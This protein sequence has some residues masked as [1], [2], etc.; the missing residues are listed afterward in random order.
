MGKPAVA[1]PQPR[2]R[3]K[4]NLH[5]PKPPRLPLPFVAPSLLQH[6]LHSGQ[7]TFV[8]SCR[9][10]NRSPPLEES[11]V[12]PRKIA[13]C[14]ALL[15]IS[16]RSAQCDGDGQR[17]LPAHSARAAC[18][19]GKEH[20]DVCRRSP[21]PCRDSLATRRRAVEPRHP[22]ALRPRSRHACHSAIRYLLSAG[23]WNRG[24]VRR[25]FGVGSASVR[26]RFGAGLAPL[27]CRFGVG[28]SRS[29]L[30]TW[31]HRRSQPPASTILMPTILQ[32]HLSKAIFRPAQSAQHS[33]PSCQIVAGARPEYQKRSDSFTSRWLAESNTTALPP[34]AAIT[35]ARTGFADRRQA[36]RPPRS[37]PAA[38]RWK[39][40]RPARDDAPYPRPRAGQHRWRC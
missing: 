30:H 13:K 34:C 26:R 8:P 16:D 35:W 22:R 1:S 4:T 3:A 29:H 6:E 38:C 37:W 28:L 19:R 21:S 24:L 18:P 17:A 12:F 40:R 20:D 15:R 39:Y 31:I 27:W 33:S 36:C 11:A 5:S 7:S 32:E 9:C 23:N 10:A 2:P 25:R 14:V